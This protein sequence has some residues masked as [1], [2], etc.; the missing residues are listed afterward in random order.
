MENTITGLAETARKQ[1]TRITV[2]EKALTEELEIKRR[3]LEKLNEYVDNGVNVT[4][5]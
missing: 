4:F 3:L 2:L 5:D 1:E